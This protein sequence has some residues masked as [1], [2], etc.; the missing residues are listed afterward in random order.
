MKL[1]LK[2]KFIAD[3]Q[4][5]GYQERT[6][7]SYYRAVRQLENFWSLPAEDVVEDQVRE[8]F[9]FCQNEIEWKPAT[10]RIAYSGIKFFYTTTL[11]SD[12]ETLKM[13]KIKRIT[14]PPT[15]L[16]FDEVRLILKTA[17][18]PQLKT[19]LTTVYSCGLR[20]AEALALTV[21]DIDKDRM[22]LIVRSGKGGKY[23]E[24]PLPKSTYEALKEYWKT[25]R[26]PTW[27]FPALGKNGKKGATAVKPMATSSIEGALRRLRT[28]LP[29]IKK[30][31]LLHTLRH[32]YATHLIEAGVGVRIVQQ[33]LGHSSLTTTM[34]YLHVTDQGGSDATDR[35]NRLMGGLS[36]D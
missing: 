1:S 10:M 13:M 23:R 3:M 34:I 5:N 31:F 17:R 7:D 21:N 14:T 25:H 27:L 35:I 30:H 24:V 28:E 19:F 9:L 29:Q 4:L 6:R 22:V 2:K 26:N 36:D 11:P 33:Y 15:V 18:T 20:R 32:S 8:Y 12:F 16:S